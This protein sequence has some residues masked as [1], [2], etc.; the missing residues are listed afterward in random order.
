LEGSS[1]GLWTEE[2]HRNLSQNGQSLGRDLNQG[3]PKYEAGMITTRPQRLVFQRCLC[4][5]HR[6]DGGRKHL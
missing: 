4:L 5:H 3:P 6:D 1:H 2:N